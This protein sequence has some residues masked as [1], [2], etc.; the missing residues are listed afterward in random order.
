MPQKATR[1]DILNILEQRRAVQDGNAA[2]A[3][4]TA[5]VEPTSATSPGTTPPPLRVVIPGEGAPIIPAVAAPAVSDADLDKFLQA[6]L[7]KFVRA[8][9]E[10]VRLPFRWSEVVTLAEVVSGAVAFGLPLAKGLEARQLVLVIS[11]YVFDTYAASLLSPAVRPFAGLLRGLLLVGVEA[12]YQ[13]SV[14]ART[15]T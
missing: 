10:L 5:S 15:K 9:E 11:A 7:P 2:R 13:L 4:S 3:L 1:Q 6:Y 12:A 8:A 14:K